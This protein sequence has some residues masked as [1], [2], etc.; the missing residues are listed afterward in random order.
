M[1]EKNVPI[2]LGT[3]VARFRHVFVVDEDLREKAL[4]D[5][6]L[7]INDER[8]K[9]ANMHIH[10]CN[11]VSY[12]WYSSEAYVLT[13][14]FFRLEVDMRSGVSMSDYGWEWGPIHTRRKIETSSHP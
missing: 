8:V 4:H 6:D 11:K 9:V 2:E 13:V 10:V 1:D 5:L 7:A 14:H 3:D 12:V